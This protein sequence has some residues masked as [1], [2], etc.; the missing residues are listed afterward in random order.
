ME[1]E[2]GLVRKGKDNRGIENEERK[3]LLSVRLICAESQL[4]ER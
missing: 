4:W 1:I 3:T 2:G